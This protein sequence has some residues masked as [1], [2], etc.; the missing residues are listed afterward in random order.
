MVEFLRE[1]ASLLYIGPLITGVLLGQFVF[2]TGPRWMI[3]L[4]VALAC[5]SLII[6]IPFKGWL[7]ILAA[8]SFVAGDLAGRKYH[9]KAVE[10]R[11]S[12][13]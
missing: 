1:N 3:L 5:V 2:A 13:N 10:A 4:E 12:S 6:A 11:K 9:N 8:L 7:S